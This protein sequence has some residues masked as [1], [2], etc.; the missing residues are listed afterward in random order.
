MSRKAA[1]VRAEISSDQR[2][3]KK[4][5]L[6]DQLSRSLWGSNSFASKLVPEFQ[7]LASPSKDFVIVLHFSTVLTFFFA[8][9]V[10]EALKIGGEPLP[11][12]ELEKLY[13][14]FPF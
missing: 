3:S 4:F 7:R 8:T 13:Q 2:I 10:E 6:G 5:L 9:S 14:S 11:Q 12:C 1:N